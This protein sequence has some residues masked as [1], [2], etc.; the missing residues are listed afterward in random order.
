LNLP[1]VWPHETLPIGFEWTEP[2][3]AT[4]I[5]EVLDSAGDNLDTTT[6][7]RL[8]TDSFSMPARRL[9]TLLA[10]L[11]RDDHELSKAL[12][13]L[14]NWDFVLAA[15]S[16]P[17]LLFELWYTKHLRAALFAAL[18]PVAAQPLL[19][20]G[21]VEGI[22][23]A[24][25]APDHRWGETP[26]SARDSLLS[27]TLK[28]AWS[29]AQS[30]FGSTTDHWRW[31]ALHNGYFEHPLTSLH[32]AYPAT[33]LDI[34][35]L[36][37]GGSA[38]SPMH[39]GYR[40]SDFRV[41]HGASFRMVVD[42]ADLDSSLTINAPGQSGDPRSAHYADLAPLWARCEYVPMLWSDSAIVAATHFTW[43]LTPAGSA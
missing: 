14:L 37:K 5:R 40:P 22:C 3:R 7:T 33:A 19:P 39:A 1:S 8:Q 18:V 36:P 12:D 21:D 20:P 13:Y 31:G 32:R 24:L 16:G 42:L 17:A 30:R 27:R 9:C 10:R 34:G 41:T 26:S 6:S 29:E 11:P 4:R 38:S 43:I 25:E 28:A 35:P 15:D 23:R 2:S